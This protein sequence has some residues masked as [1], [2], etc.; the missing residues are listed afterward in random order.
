MR[1]LLLH[2]WTRS[3]GLQVSGGAEV[4]LEARVVA[5]DGARMCAQVKQ[6]HARL[7]PVVAQGACRV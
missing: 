5:D 1:A 4:R 3:L 6:S 2:I 7:C